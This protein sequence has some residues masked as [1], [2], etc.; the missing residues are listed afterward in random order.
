LSYDD[1]YAERESL[2]AP[3]AQII[4]VLQG[5]GAYFCRLFDVNTFDLH[6]GRIGYACDEFML[7]QGRPASE[8][9]VVTPKTAPVASNFQ[10]RRPAN[11]GSTRL[12]AAI[13]HSG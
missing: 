3:A 5:D 11:S 9:V 1:W 6:I 7:S 2:I 10:A 8:L 12:P 13:F 4:V